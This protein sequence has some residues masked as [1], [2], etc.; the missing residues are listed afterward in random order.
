MRKHMTARSALQGIIVY[1]GAYFGLYDTALQVLP[2]PLSEHARCLVDASVLPCAL[3]LWMGLV[4][5]GTD[6]IGG[7]CVQ[8]CVQGSWA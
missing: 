4:P 6:T 1:R 5:A 7:G 2:C 8:I 3:R